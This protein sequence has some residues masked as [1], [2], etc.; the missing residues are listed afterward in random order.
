MRVL[1][2]VPQP[3]QEGRIGAYT[4]LDEEIQ[5]LAAAGIEAYVLSTAS[6]ADSRCGAVHLI[7]S[8][9]RSSAVKRWAATGFLA[10]AALKAGVSQ[11]QHPLIWYRAAWREYLAAEIVEQYKIDLLHSHFAWPAGSGGLLA[12]A[13]TGRPLVASLRGTDILRDATIGYGRRANPGFDAALRK[14]LKGADRTVYFSEYMRDQG[15]ALGAKPESARVI[16]KG[17]DLSQF[18]VAADRAALKQDL[19]VGPGPMIL[20]VGGLIQRKGIHHLL[21]ALGPLRAS[22]EFTFVVCGDGPERAA[23]EALSERLGLSERTM[24]VGRVDR[25]TIPRYFAACDLFA[26]AST[27]EAAGNVLFEAMASGRPVVCTRAGGPQEYVVDGLTGFVVPVGDIGQLADRVQRLLDDPFLR[28]ELGREGRRRALEEFSYGRMVADL[29][30]VYD[31]VLRTS[32]ARM[33]A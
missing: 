31:D 23:L 29:T 13:I 21:E 20:T 2:L 8:D 14:L 5:A 9:A 25:E 19:G 10:R 33:M 24:F 6:P 32:P 26:L 7:S 4:F 1:Y 22:Y 16:R 11:A 30:G 12:S 17:V 28:D 18:T 27:V 3:K 15:M